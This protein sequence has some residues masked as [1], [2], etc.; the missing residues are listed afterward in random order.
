MLLKNQ[1]ILKNKEILSKYGK[2]ISYAEF[3]GNKVKKKIESGRSYCFMYLIIESEVNQFANS[4][5]KKY[6]SIKLTDSTKYRTLAVDFKERYEKFLKINVRI[7]DRHFV[8]DTILRDHILSFFKINKNNDLFIIVK[9]EYIKQFPESEH[10]I[11]GMIDFCQGKDL[12][13]QKDNT[14]KSKMKIFQTEINTLS[15]KYK[16]I[17]LITISDSVLIKYS[18]YIISKDRKLIHDKFNFNK[19]IYLFKDIRKIVRKI[20]TMNVYGIFCYGLNKCKAIKSNSPNVVHLGILS[21]EFKKIFEIEAKCRALKKDKKGDLYTERTLYHSYRH[22]NRKSL[23]RSPK[24][25]ILVKQEWGMNEK[26]I[27]MTKKL[28]GISET[29]IIISKIPDKPFYYQ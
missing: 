28:N 18:F 15:L 23:N 20:F 27:D 6:G 14:I 5:N 21:H 24:G 7:E 4:I 25:P 13:L 26:D 19:I 16:D 12:F 8:P 11:V 29:D 3:K 17:A 1:T 9:D 22:Y 2:L 10:C